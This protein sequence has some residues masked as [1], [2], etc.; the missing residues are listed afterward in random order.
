MASALILPVRQAATLPAVASAEASKVTSGATVAGTPASPAAGRTTFTVAFS[1]RGGA[2]FQSAK[3]SPQ[4]GRARRIAPATSDT[5]FTPSS[6]AGLVPTRCSNSRWLFTGVGVT[7]ATFL[8]ASAGTAC[9]HAASAAWMHAV[10]AGVR[11]S[12]V[13]LWSTPASVTVASITTCVLLSAPRF[14]GSTRHSMT[15]G[16]A[17]SSMPRS[18]EGVACPATAGGMGASVERSKYQRFFTCSFVTT[19]AA[20]AAGAVAAGCSGPHAAE[21]T[22]TAR[23]RRAAARV[24]GGLI[25]RIGGRCLGAN[26]WPTS[27]TVRGTG[28]PADRGPRGR[29]ARAPGARRPSSATRAARSRACRRAAGG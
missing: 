10:P 16:R 5:S 20:D 14:C 6:T 19:G 27:R 1:V 4:C 8:A 2:A 18:A 17:A 26:G 3:Q 22:A 9:V 7:G 15:I 29:R 28:R 13:T 23:R 11:F 12:P 24:M 21:A 25:A